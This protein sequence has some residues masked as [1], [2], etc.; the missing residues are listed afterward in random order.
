MPT[1][2]RQFNHAYLL[3]GRE[4]RAELSKGVNAVTARYMVMLEEPLANDE[5]PDN[6]TGRSS[7]TRT[8]RSAGLS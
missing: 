7:A 1:Q 8:R 2:T 3:D 6:I 4:W 5:L